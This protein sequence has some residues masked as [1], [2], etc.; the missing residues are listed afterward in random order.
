MKKI[1]LIL[2]TV[3]FA[4]SVNAHSTKGV[5]PNLDYNAQC[6]KKKSVLNFISK[7]RLFKGKGEK[8]IEKGVTIGRKN[9][10]QYMPQFINFF[11]ENLL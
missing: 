3:L 7:H 4:S 1:I 8:C 10:D 9:M 2:I 11:K 5:T 6:T